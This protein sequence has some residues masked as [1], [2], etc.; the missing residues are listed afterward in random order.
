[1]HR[2]KQ[3]LIAIAKAIALLL[4]VATLALII[5]SFVRKDWI[6]SGMA[7]IGELVHSLGNWNYLVAF[8]SACIESLPIIGTAVPGMNIM[9]IVGGFWGKEH[10][11]LTIVVA[12]IG[13]MLGNWIG[14]WIGKE[15]GSSLIEK[16]GDWFWVGKTEEKILHKQLEKNG[17]WYVTLGKFHNFTRAFIPFIAGTG[18]MLAQRFWTYNMIGSI[19]WATSINLLGVYFIDNYE[20]IL[21]NLGKIMF[22]VLIWV[23][24]Y[25]WFFRRQ[26]LVN[27]WNA[28]N[29]EIEEKIAKK[30]SNKREEEKE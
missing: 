7:W 17:F 10:L 4:T 25:F 24:G 23:F 15:I 14:Y 21:E 20:F 27:Y 19:V 30:T 13:A 28:K 22:A 29:R 2:I 5:I 26:S 3:S 1:M 6:T 9:I 12:S 18:G 11:I 8:A 16:Y